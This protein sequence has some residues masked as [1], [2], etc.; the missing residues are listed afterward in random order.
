MMTED[1]ANTKWCPFARVIEADMKRGGGYQHPAQQTA[2]NR[3]NVYGIGERGTADTIPK[4]A[5]TR[6]A[7][8]IGSACMAWRWE[9]DQ[10]YHPPSERG[11]CG[12]A[13][14]PA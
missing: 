9:H 3:L 7:N 10:P 5:W 12:L 11:F 8:C 1:E 14:R 2:Y 4:A 6:A 13:G